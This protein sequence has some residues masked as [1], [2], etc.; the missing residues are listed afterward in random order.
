MVAWYRAAMTSPTAV[1][2]EPAY[3]DPDAVLAVIRTGGPFWPLARYGASPEELQALGG[4]AR[5]FTPPWFRQDFALAGRA[6]VDGAELI[7]GNRRFS[8]AAQEIYGSDAIVRP[9]TVYV[10]V[11]GPTPFPFA[12]HLDVP[13]FRT[14]TRADHPIWLLKVMK[15]SGLFE[16]ERI[17]IATAVSWFYEGRGGEFHYWPTGPDGEAA[18][19]RPPFRN[20]A[21]VADNEATYHGVAPLGAVGSEM[22]KGL[23]HDSRLVRSGDHWDVIEA[24]DVAASYD[25][26]AARITVSWKADVFADADHA[27]ECDA[28][29]GGLNLETVVDRLCTDLRERGVEIE[30]PSEPLQD[31]TWIGTLAEVYRDPAPALV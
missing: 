19:Q 12:P 4:S 7:L 10:N 29:V 8:G 28:G 11:M 17:H 22:P 18:I 21:V 14:F 2:L 24:G 31:R 6:V 25:D 13:A 3:D 5:Q 15:S 20:V 27:A 30:R 9:T 26:A 1:L 16:D 23:T